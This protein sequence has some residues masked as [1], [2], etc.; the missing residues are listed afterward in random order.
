[1]NPYSNSNGRNNADSN[2]INLFNGST[3]NHTER[4]DTY[5][6]QY[7]QYNQYNQNTQEF[8][9]PPMAMQYG[10]NFSPMRQGE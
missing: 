9:R 3:Q 7:N 4:I 6:A 10:Q 5:S 1:M 8:N 2:H